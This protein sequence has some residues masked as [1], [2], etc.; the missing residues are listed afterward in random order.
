MAIVDAQFKTLDSWDHFVVHSDAFPKLIYNCIYLKIFHPK[1]NMTLYIV[2]K[3]FH[4]KDL[5]GQILLLFKFVSAFGFFLNYK[6]KHL[7]II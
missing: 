6:P 4:T 5:D 1:S 3:G 2:K 7:Y